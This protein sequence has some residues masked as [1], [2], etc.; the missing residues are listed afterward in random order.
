M[1][2]SIS[3]PY[4]VESLVPHRPPMLLV[5]QILERNKNTGLVDAIIPDNSI[6][7]DPEFGILPELYVE[8]IAQAMA[9]ISGWDALVGNTPTVKGLLVGLSDIK[10]IG[11]INPG[12]LLL[13][14]LEKKLEFGG[15]TIMEGVLRSE[16][17]IILQGDVKVWE[18]KNGNR[19]ES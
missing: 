10:F 9:A 19:A 1:D 12:E 14:E 6:F 8:I 4:P 13:I 11:K 2:Q 16:S 7:F 15:V 3:L 17:G 18:D 5:R